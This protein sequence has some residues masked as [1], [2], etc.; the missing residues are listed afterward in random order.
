MQCGKCGCELDEMENC[1]PGCLSAK[2]PF[3][4]ARLLAGAEYLRMCDEAGAGNAFGA[5]ADFETGRIT[6]WPLALEGHYLAVT[7][8]MPGVKPANDK[9]RHSRPGV[10][11]PSNSSNN[12]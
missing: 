5:I 8:K 6:M 4:P 7:F 9:L 1:C 11:E 2:P 3:A 10:T 12:L